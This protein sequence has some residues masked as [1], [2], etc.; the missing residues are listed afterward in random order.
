[1]TT[2]DSPDLTAYAKFDLATQTTTVPLFH[3]SF[4]MSLFVNVVQLFDDADASRL[5]ESIFMSRQPG[6]WVQRR[7]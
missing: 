4:S 3:V 5:W 1:M 6:N 2:S 7:L